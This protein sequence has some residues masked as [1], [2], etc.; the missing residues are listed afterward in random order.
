MAGRKCWAK[1]PFQYGSLDLGRGQVFDLRGSPNDDKLIGM[2]YVAP[3][4]K[5]MSFTTCATCGAEFIGHAE[6]RQHGDALHPARPRSDEE[7]DRFQ[8]RQEAMLET[9]APVGA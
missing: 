1:R 6:L 5:G 8:D 3:V 7:E 4:E 9:L 2:G